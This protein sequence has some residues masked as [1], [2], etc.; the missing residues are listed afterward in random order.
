MTFESSSPSLLAA[1]SI[2]RLA[3]HAACD[4]AF[5]V[6]VGATLSLAAR[7]NVIHSTRRALRSAC[8]WSWWPMQNGYAGTP[9]FPPPTSAK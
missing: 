2:C 9:R 4:A 5:E 8:P 1:I 3:W 6:A 7:C